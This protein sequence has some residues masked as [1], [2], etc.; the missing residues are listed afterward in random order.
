MNTSIGLRKIHLYSL[1]AGE[2]TTGM[3][4]GNLVVFPKF[5]STY[6]P[7]FTRLGS[8]A[9]ISWKSKLTRRHTES[10]TSWSNEH[11]TGNILQDYSKLNDNTHAPTTFPSNG[12]RGPHHNTEHDSSWLDDGTKTH[13]GILKTVRVDQGV[14][15]V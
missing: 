4:A 14:Q 12:G 2:T 10:S 7:K 6:Y 15:Y 13:Y 3:L 9:A 1:R 8:G 5:F 11:D